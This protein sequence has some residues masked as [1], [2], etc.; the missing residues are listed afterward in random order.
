MWVG[1]TSTQPTGAP[2]PQWASGLRIKSVTPGAHREFTRLLEAL[3]IEGLEN[4]GRA[5]DCNRLA[6]SRHRNEPSR[7]PGGMDQLSP[8][9]TIADDIHG[10]YSRP[11]RRSHRANF[12]SPSSRARYP[13]LE[14]LESEGNQELT[15]RRWGTRDRSVPASWQSDK[16]K[17]ARHRGGR[18]A[19]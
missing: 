11:K 10:S 17:C 6:L 14:M 2:Y 12:P 9:R 1:E 18:K 3:R 13:A 8:S 4:S 15:C 5:D 19:N 7:F 16:Q